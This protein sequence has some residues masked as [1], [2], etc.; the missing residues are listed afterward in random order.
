[1]PMLLITFVV[2]GSLAIL[3]LIARVLLALFG[4]ALPYRTEE[5]RPGSWDVM[6]M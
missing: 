1:M 3:L 5:L 4:P 2:I 6:I